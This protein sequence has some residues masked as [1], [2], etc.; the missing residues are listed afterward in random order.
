MKML[1]LHKIIYAFELCGVLNWQYVFGS[2][3]ITNCRYNDVSVGGK[4]ITPSVNCL[5]I[6]SAIRTHDLSIA[7]VIIQ[8]V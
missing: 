7:L 2:Q 1:I 3:L 6:F 4:L 5:F 8:F